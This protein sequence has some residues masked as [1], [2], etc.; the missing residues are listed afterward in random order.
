MARYTGPAS[1]LGLD[2]HDLIR[3]AVAL[4]LWASHFA[5]APP[6]IGITVATKGRPCR[7]TGRLTLVRGPA[8]IHIVIGLGAD[9]ADLALAVLHELSHAYAGAGHHRRWR[10]TLRG[11]GIQMFGVAVARRIP[12][13]RGLDFRELE[14][15]IAA[16]I[17]VALCCP[18][19]PDF[20]LWKPQPVVTESPV[21]TALCQRW[22]RA[23]A[24][25]EATPPRP[26]RRG[27]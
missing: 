27:R 2:L 14:D 23:V 25:G 17:R 7:S 5:A 6:V 26:P 12:E 19:P 10:Q 16:G 8:S 13:L 1:Y 4:P 18:P 9:R 20:L 21:P 3:R 22:Q 15:S 24:T 11:A